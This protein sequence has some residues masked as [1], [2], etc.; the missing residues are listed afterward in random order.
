[1]SVSSVNLNAIANANYDIA[2]IGGGMVG[3]PLAI[4]LARQGFSVLLVER[5][6][7]SEVPDIG[8][9]NSFDWRSTAISAGSVNI[10]SALNLWDKQALFANAIQ[11]VH[12]SEQGRMGTTSIQAEELGSEALGYVVPNI[13]VGKLFQVSLADSDVNVREHAQVSK[14]VMLADAAEV[15]TRSESSGEQVFRTSLVIVA[16]GAQS[17]CAQML[18]IDYEQK[19]Y[20]QS[21]IITNVETELPNQGVA[22]ERF[23]ATGPAALLPLQKSLS[24]LVWTLSSEEADAAMALPQ[25]EFGKRIEDIFGGRL[26][27]ICKSGERVSYPLS[28]TQAK[29]QS[30]E[31]LLVAGNAAHSLHPVA[32]QGF[33]LALRGVAAYIEGLAEHKE[34]GFWQHQVLKSLVAK[35]RL[36]QAKIVTFSDQLIDVFSPASHV[37]SLARTLGLVS[38]NSLAS[39]KAEFAKHSMGQ[40]QSLKLQQTAKLSGSVV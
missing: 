38:L 22:F 17:K 28:L 20:N 34:S 40:A 4:G 9:S 33:N 21:A 7:L 5:G 26:G 15:H 31:R 23:A 24:A 39:L 35:H 32:G 8:L 6:S 3:I 37:P 36:E 12:V 13:A 10:L 11:A 2:V 1:M 25:E 30:R 16:D 19:P 18:G 29:E 14:I 27:R